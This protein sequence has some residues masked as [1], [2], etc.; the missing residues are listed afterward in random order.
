MVKLGL[1]LEEDDKGELTGR[2]QVANEELDE[3]R[4]TF[5]TEEEAKSAMIKMQTES[6]RNDEIEKDYLKWEK[7]C[8]SHHAISQEE[9]RVFL[10]NFVMV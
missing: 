3:V 7:D 5:D 10:V 6:D 9:L 2:W 1:F 4:D 8:L